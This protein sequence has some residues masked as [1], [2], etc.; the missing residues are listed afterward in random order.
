MVKKADAITKRLLVKETK[1]QP[2]YLNISVLT[3]NKF[4]CGF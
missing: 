3:L 4:K 2:T 1:L